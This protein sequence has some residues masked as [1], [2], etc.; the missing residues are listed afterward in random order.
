VKQAE[1]ALS[2]EAREA[3][4]TLAAAAPPVFGR[5]AAPAKDKLEQRFEEIHPSPPAPHRLMR[6][7]P[8]LARLRR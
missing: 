1:A 7:S 8:A 6:N 2:A 5:R 3:P 4:L